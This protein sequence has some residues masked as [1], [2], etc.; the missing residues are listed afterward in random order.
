MYWVFDRYIAHRLDRQRDI[1]TQN[2]SKI[3]YLR[4]NIQRC[5]NK[6]K[7]KNIVWLWEPLKFKY[8]TFDTLK[9]AQYFSSKRMN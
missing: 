5:E 9:Y 3:K 6:T 7:Q 2:C 8:A 4:M 1:Q